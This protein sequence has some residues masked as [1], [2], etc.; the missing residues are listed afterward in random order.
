MDFGHRHYVPI[1]KTKLGERWALSHLDKTTIKNL[2]PLLEL[3]PHKAKAPGTHV[4]EICEALEAAWGNDREVFLDTFWLHPGKK[5][6]E[7][8]KANGDPKVIRA[9]LD[10][11]RL[12]LKAVPVVRLGFS[13]SSRDEVRAAM[14]KDGLGFMLRLRPSELKSEDMISA[15]LKD[16]NAKPET[17]HLL[18]DYKTSQMNLS[19][20]VPRVPFVT[21]WRTFTSA[22]GAFP[23]SLADSAL[24]KWFKIPRSDWAA[25]DKATA[26]AGLGRKPTF[27]DY[28]TRDPGGPVDGG[29]PSVNLRYTREKHWLVRVGGKV[30]EGAAPQMK[31]VCKSLVSM[32][33]D[34]DGPDF[35]E[36]DNEI[37]KTAQHGTGPG[38][39]GQW[40]KWG[41]SHHMVLTAAAAFA[42][43]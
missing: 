4:V 27:A 28:T 33:D 43:A 37:F 16:L 25:W 32:S 42:H 18:L 14:E 12:H 10:C 36:G 17:G 13:K 8:K 7:V 2:S 20:D 22:S 21:Q 35:S 9:C 26:G 1:L 6:D 5:S 40:V 31:Q 11:A 39:P 30:K 24:D 41:V 23:R 19:F 3:H 38:N 15:L 29:S 34:Y